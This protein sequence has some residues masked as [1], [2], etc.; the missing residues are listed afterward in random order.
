MFAKNRPATLHV[1]PS[2]GHGWGYQL[3]FEHHGWML[4]DLAHW[5]YNQPNQ[6]NLQLDKQ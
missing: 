1:Y 2:G 6:P 5:L 4:D 3:S